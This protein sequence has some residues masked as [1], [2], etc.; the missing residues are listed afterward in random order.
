MSDLVLFLKRTQRKLGYGMVACAGF[1]L[2]I[3]MAWGIVYAVGYGNL[4]PIL[5]AL[6]M[7]GVPM[8]FAVV[9]CWLVERKIQ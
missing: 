1:G 5:G 4:S 9:G 7:I 3:P 2:S 6:L 8:V